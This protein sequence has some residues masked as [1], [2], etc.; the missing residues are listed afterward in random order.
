MFAPKRDQNVFS[1]WCEA[2]WWQLALELSHSLRSNFSRLL[3]LPSDHLAYGVWGL[4]MMDFRLNCSA[5]VV[6]WLI[7]HPIVQHFY[8]AQHCM[9]C[10]T[11]RIDNQPL[12]FI[13]SGWTARLQGLTVIQKR[14][15]K[16]KKSLWLLIHQRKLI[17][18]EGEREKKSLCLCVCMCC[19]EKRN[20]SFVLPNKLFDRIPNKKD[21][22][23]I[24]LVV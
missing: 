10:C 14:K 4:I 17:C 19:G 23:S 8:P 1:L 13:N 11:K 9:C 15:K 22:S 21:H 12:I 20:T 18:P 24:R 3:L 5:D 6:N 16:K 2:D 7:P